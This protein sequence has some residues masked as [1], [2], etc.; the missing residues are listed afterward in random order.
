MLNIIDTLN[1]WIQPFKNFILKNY[2]NPIFWT[3]LVIIG[4]LVFS[5]TYNALNKNK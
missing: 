2:G 4:L 3:A 1:E 5:F